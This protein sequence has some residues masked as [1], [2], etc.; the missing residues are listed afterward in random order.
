[1][2]TRKTTS[3]QQKY[4]LLFIL[5]VIFLALFVLP[6]NVSGQAA[7][8]PYV[9]VDEMPLFPGGEPALMKYIASNLQY[10][11][12]SMENN[13]QGKVIIRFCV[14]AE[15]GINQISVL[16]GVDPDLDKEAVRVV[17]KLP[18][19]KPGK[20]DGVAVPV[21]YMVPITFRLSTK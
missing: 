4:R 1:M 12:I 17:N 14:T 9:A 15:G 18:A 6:S 2:K 21:W 7:Q 19:F 11:S 20:K 13:V 3:P 16:K 5:P 10:P 8:T